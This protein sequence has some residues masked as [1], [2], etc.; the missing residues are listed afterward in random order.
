MVTLEGIKE[1]QSQMFEGS[2][3]KLVN[4][5]YQKEILLIGFV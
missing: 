3:D 5:G 4:F 1:T 2:I